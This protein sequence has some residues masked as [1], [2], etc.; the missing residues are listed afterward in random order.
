M[1]IS[2]LGFCHLNKARSIWV[3]MKW[4]LNWVKCLLHQTAYRKGKGHFLYNDEGWGPS[5]LWLVPLLTGG[6]RV[7]QRANWGRG[8]RQASNLHSC[9]AGFCFSSCLQVPALTCLSNSAWPRGFVRWKQ[10]IL[11]SQAAFI[12][13][14]HPSNRNPKAEISTGSEVLLR[15]TR[16]MFL[17]RLWKVLG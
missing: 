7:F 5:P 4:H 8:G 2:W 14:F 11:S 10:P 6:P 13:V 3:F 16:P 17:G 15:Q 9:T 1:I 12:I